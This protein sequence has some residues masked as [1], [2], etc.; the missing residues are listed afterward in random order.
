MTPPPSTVIRNEFA[1]PPTASILWLDN[2]HVAAGHNQQS[3]KTVLEA[4]GYQVKIVS[5]A[6]FREAPGINDTLLV[7]PHAAGLK[8]TEGQQ[9]LVLRY[10]GSGGNVVADGSQAWLA[11]IGFVFSGTQTIVSSVTDPDH[12]DVK[13]TWRPEEHI[14]R[15]TPP[16]NVR[17]LMDDD[18]SGQPVALAGSFGAGPLHISGD[19]ILTTIPTTAP[20]TIP[21]SPSISAL[22]S[23]LRLRC[24]AATSRCTSIPDDRPG[25]DLNRLATIWHRAGISTVHV[26]AWDFT[27]QYSF[28]YDEFVRACHRNGIA[29]YAWFCVPHGD[30]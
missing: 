30:S 7:V 25:A 20:A 23:E 5:A 4:L 15:F 13:L 6:K 8:L 12:S 2:P 27:R 9:R 17:E 28:P 16:E 21:T 10:L 11:K 24:A 19:A 18:E 1:G 26:K 14:A 22:P 29:V 3:Y